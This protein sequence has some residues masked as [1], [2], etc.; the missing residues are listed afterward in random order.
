MTRLSTGKS[1]LWVGLALLLTTTNACTR[2]YYRRQADVDAARLTLEKINHPHWD[3]P[4]QTIAI[5]PRSRMFDPFSPDCEP[6]PPDDPYSHQLM[7][8]VDGKKGW[9]KWHQFG[10]TNTVENPSWLDHLPLDENGVLLLDSERAYQLALLHSRDYQ[11][12]FETLYLSALDVSAERFRFDTQFFGGYSARY[13]TTGRDRAPRSQLTTGFTTR[14][15][16][17]FGLPTG[18]TAPSDADVLIRRAF[19]TGGELAVGIANSLTWDLA[20]PNNYSSLT[21]LDFSF[22]QPLLRLAGRERVL[23][24]LTLSERQLLANVRQMERYRQAFFV[25]MY[26]GRDAGNGATRRGGLFGGAGLEG[27]TGVGGGGFGRVGGANTGGGN[28]QLTA[29]QAGGFL[30]LLQQQQNVRIQAANVAGLR[31]NLAQLRE[32]LRENLTMIPDV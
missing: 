3:L 28:T 9:R 8:N 6:M 15:T 21:I 29:P 32:A 22:V 7:H 27:F 4:R 30:G 1:W 25:E 10:D 5:D 20:G 11:E 14:E 24:Q 13:T 23:E 18:V 31:T 16:G 19:A 12:Q 26:T 2:G 17:R